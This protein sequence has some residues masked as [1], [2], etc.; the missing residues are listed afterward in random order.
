MPYETRELLNRINT[1]EGEIQKLTEDV[2]ILQNIT[3]LIATRH[4]GHDRLILELLNQLSSTKTTIIR[5][6]ETT[7]NDCVD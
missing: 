4:C 3:R 6:G 2:F 7:D 1:L 5:L